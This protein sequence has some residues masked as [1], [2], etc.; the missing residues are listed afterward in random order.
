MK[1]IH[2]RSPQGSP[3][4]KYTI[5]NTTNKSSGMTILLQLSTLRHLSHFNRAFLPIDKLFN[6]KYVLTLPDVFTDKHHC[7][8]KI[9]THQYNRGMEIALPLMPKVITCFH[10]LLLTCLIF[11]KDTVEEC[12]KFVSIPRHFFVKSLFYLGERQNST[13]SCN[14]F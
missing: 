5:Q 3:W 10:P 12:W 8:F 1:F 9:D 4:Y 2:K 7:S 13:K 6:C 14:M 11:S